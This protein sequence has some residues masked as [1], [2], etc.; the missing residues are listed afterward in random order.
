MS[1]TRAS[2]FEPERVRREHLPGRV[3]ALVAGEGG[4]R[5]ASRPGT[6][7]RE[8]VQSSAEA[9]LVKTNQNKKKVARGDSVAAGS[10]ARR[11]PPTYL[12]AFAVLLGSPR[13]MAAILGLGVCTSPTAMAASYQRFDGV[14]N[15]RSPK[16]SSTIV[17]TRRLRQPSL[18]AASSLDSRGSLCRGAQSSWRVFRACAEL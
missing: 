1:L 3:V 6:W 9:C 8:G 11:A 5:V 12:R 16:Q 2:Q 7:G 14:I 4:H 13:S 10:A 18:F 17:T 15:S